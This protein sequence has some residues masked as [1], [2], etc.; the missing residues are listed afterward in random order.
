MDA[1][2]PAAP[3]RSW[4]SLVTGRWHVSSRAVMVLTLLVLVFCNLPGQFVRHLQYEVGHPFY[5]ESGFEHGWPLTYL[6]RS[7]EDPYESVRPAYVSV[8]FPVPTPSTVRNC[9]EVWRDGDAFLPWSLVSNLC[10]LLLISM[11]S[12][13]AFE[14]WRRNRNRLWHLHLKDLFA[15]TLLA[16]LVMAWYV[17]RQRQHAVEE[18]IF[19]QPSG[20]PSL[21]ENQTGGPTWLR[22]C[23]GDDSFQFL[24]CPFEVAISEGENWS[25]LEKL[26]AV[27][28]VEGRARATTEQLAHLAKM[29]R[30]EA[31]TLEEEL[32]IP[33]DTI[34]A[35]LP[36][37]PNLRGLYLSQPAC[38][39]RRIDRL[40]SL[41]AVRIGEGSVDEQVL[42]ELSV[43]PNLRQV[44][45][46]GLFESADLSFLPSRQFL[47]GLEFYNGDISGAALKDIGKCSRLK[48]LSFYMCRVDGSGI[49]HLAGLVNLETLNL[50]YTDVTSADLAELG[51]LK[52]L[53]E[54]ELTAT[55]VGGDMQFLSDLENLETLQLYDTKVT[56]ED[57]TPLIGLKHL[58]SLDLGYT[59]LR[60]NGMAFLKQMKQLTWLRVSNFDEEELKALQAALPECE[61]LRH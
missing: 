37:L 30:L 21:Q 29:P 10:V 28:H 20:A 61:I 56:A 12:G 16:S 9:F 32:G 13:V 23:L 25:Q 52:R 11:G 17:H 18:A 36:P 45:L 49:R 6:T 24:D 34:V 48:D 43:L 59:D 55:K 44:A 50:E 26:T 58:R 22:L 46:D 35:E 15:A 4:R 31:L 42:R 27:R 60:P 1:S 14:A 7:V 5:V 57:L 33:P 8:V 39:C 3:R 51:T 19:S 53:R 40:A 47:S 38:R 41:E 54:L 2:S